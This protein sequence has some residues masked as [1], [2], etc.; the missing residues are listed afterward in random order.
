MTPD[1]AAVMAQVLTEH[2]AL[3]NAPDGPFTGCECGGVKLGEGVQQHV[4]VELAKALDAAGCTLTP[5]VSYTMVPERTMA[6][7][8][9]DS[10]GAEDPAVTW[11]DA[12]GPLGS[13][14]R[15]YAFSDR[16][17]AVWRALLQHTD[18]Q[19]AAEE[20]HRAMAAPVPLEVGGPTPPPPTTDWAAQAWAAREADVAGGTWDPAGENPE[21]VPVF[22]QGVLPAPPGVRGWRCPSCGMESEPVSLETVPL[23]DGSGWEEPALVHPEVA[24][25]PDPGGR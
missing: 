9:V 8:L 2:H 25:V 7:L 18:R 11:A 12:S 3:M 16:D 1:P 19:L 5:G 13:P 23:C 20:G 4:A 22:G 24:M 10:T 14:R 21:E 17:L 15:G 6:V